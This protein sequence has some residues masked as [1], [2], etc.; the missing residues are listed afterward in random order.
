MK[1]LL[2]LSAFLLAGCVANGEPFDASALPKAHQDKAQLVIYRPNGFVASG[3]SAGIEINGDKVCSLPVRGF[4][5]Q[6]VDAGKVTV[7]ARHFGA[8]SL[9]FKADSGK[10]YYIRVMPQGGKALA[11]GF[12]GLIGWGMAEAASDEGGFFTARPIEAEDA[13]DEIAETKEMACN[14]S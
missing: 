10:R 14:P 6:E 7:A 2:I 4:M 12:G 9:K 11:G 5:T 13:Q 3:V 1:K 8:S